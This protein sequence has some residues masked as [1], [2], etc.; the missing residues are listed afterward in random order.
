[1]KVS[2]LITFKGTPSWLTGYNLIV[3][4]AISAL[5]PIVTMTAHSNGASQSNQ[6]RP[7]S[8]VGEIQEWP[9]AKVTISQS[10]LD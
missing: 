9:I 1:M 5:T 10:R 8:L 4:F 2:S 3:R 6:R 7:E